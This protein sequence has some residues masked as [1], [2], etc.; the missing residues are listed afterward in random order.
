MMKIKKQIIGGLLIGL[1]ILMTGCTPATATPDVAATVAIGVSIA[2]TASVIQT[3]AAM[4]ALAIM[5]QTPTETPTPQPT[6][7]EEFT[8]TPEKVMLTFTNDT[9]CRTGTV[10]ASPSVTLLT[11][12]QSVEVLGLDPT[13]NFYLV[14][15][16]NHTYSKCWVWGGYATVSGDKTTKPVYTPQPLPTATLTLK[17][18]PDFTVTYVGMQTCGTDYYFRFNIKNTGQLIWQA[19]QVDITDITT[20]TKT[21]HVNSS[22]VDYSGCAASFSQSDLTPTED[23]TIAAYSPGQL[24]YDPTSH[25]INA[26]FTLC[27]TDTGGC[28]SKMISFTP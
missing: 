2:Q 28:I 26:A 8:A 17:P 21:T 15:D 19:F 24:P 27:Q 3:N 18:Q 22:F 4:T 10:S 14:V 9:Y 6:A 13:G 12:G 23:G 11:A 25:S 20:S 7:T 5:Q 1:F 16:P